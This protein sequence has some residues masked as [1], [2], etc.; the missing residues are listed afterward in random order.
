MD[1]D[2]KLMPWHAYSVGEIYMRPKS[3]VHK[4][5]TSK[6]ALYI[7]CLTSGETPPHKFWKFSIL[8][9]ILARF[10]LSLF[11]SKMLSL[12]ILNDD[13]D[14]FQGLIIKWCDE[15]SPYIILGLIN[16]PFYQHP[17]EFIE[18]GFFGSDKWTSKPFISIQMNSDS[19]PAG[20]LS[21]SLYQCSCVSASTSCALFILFWF[22]SFT[23]LLLF[24]PFSSLYCMLCWVHSFELFM[25]CIRGL[26]PNQ[27]NKI[28]Q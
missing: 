15:L 16:E 21:L 11:I 28:K 10:F 14:I 8:Y 22:F 24:P 19:L 13:Q 25:K 1:N 5:K 17:N 27:K 4:Q 23:A 6:R 12:S 7:L 9:I 20:L 2:V 18:F 3:Y 26:R